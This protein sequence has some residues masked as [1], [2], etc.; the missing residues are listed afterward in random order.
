MDRRPN[1]PAVKVEVRVTVEATPSHAREEQAGGH[2]EPLTEW[3]A[4]E[5]PLRTLPRAHRDR[6]AV[7]LS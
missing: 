3:T 1:A 5:P 7:K 2:E 6:L 4:V